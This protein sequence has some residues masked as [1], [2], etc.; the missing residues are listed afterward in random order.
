[1][2]LSQGVCDSSNGDH[3]PI[4][5]YGSCSLLSANGCAKFQTG[6]TMA[7]L[8]FYWLLVLTL[9]RVLLLAGEPAC[10]LGASQI[11]KRMMD[12]IDAKFTQARLLGHMDDR[13]CLYHYNFHFYVGLAVRVMRVC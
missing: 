10:R 9:G 5:T 12:L 7:A 6:W 3:I 4:T 2:E 8:W 13:S 11:V 1:M